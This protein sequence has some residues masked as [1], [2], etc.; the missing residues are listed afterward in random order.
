M[1]VLTSLFIEIWNYVRDSCTLP[2]ITN[3]WV[4]GVWLSLSVVMS[5]GHILSNTLHNFILKVL[6]S[7][8]LVLWSQNLL[9]TTSLKCMQLSS[10]AIPIHW[11]MVG[12][13]LQWAVWFLTSGDV[14][15]WAVITRL[16]ST[17]SGQ[18]CGRRQGWNSLS[19]FVEVDSSRLRNT[20]GGRG[21]W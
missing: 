13:E 11:E 21:H 8:I 6:L 4:A 15:S 18:S 12:I 17:F 14:K 10:R 9:M 5:L 16:I 2:Q 1:L 20:E 3:K 7:F 19:P